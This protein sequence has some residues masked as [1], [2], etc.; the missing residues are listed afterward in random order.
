MT[1]RRSA[2]VHDDALQLM[3]FLQPLHIVDRRIGSCFDAA[4]IGVGR[5]VPADRRV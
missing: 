5:G 1:I 2:K 3:A 4:M